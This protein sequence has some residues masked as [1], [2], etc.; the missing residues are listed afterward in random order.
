MKL[1]SVDNSQS[2]ISIND[3]APKNGRKKWRK[4]TYQDA[5]QS[6]II[7]KSKMTLMKGKRKRLGYLVY[8]LGVFTAP[9]NHI[10]DTRNA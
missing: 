7:L 9:F 1:Q 5:L 4:H 10:C 3:S 2:G 6:E 8:I